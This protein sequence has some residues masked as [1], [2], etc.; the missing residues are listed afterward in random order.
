[1]IEAIIED[2]RAKQ[3]VFKEAEKEASAKCIF[4]TNT[5]SIP[6]PLCQHTCRLKNL[7]LGD[8]NGKIYPGI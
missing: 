1:M 8:K 4:A 3:Q 7:V 5:S 2:I 6:F